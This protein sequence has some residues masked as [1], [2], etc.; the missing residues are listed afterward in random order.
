[1]NECIFKIV[2]DNASVPSGLAGEPPGPSPTLKSLESPRIVLHALCAR[3]SSSGSVR[4]SIHSFSTRALNVH[5]GHALFWN[6][7]TP[8]AGKQ[9]AVCSDVSDL[10]RPH[11]KASRHSVT[12]SQRSSLHWPFPA[13]PH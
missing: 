2:T 6:L 7:G 11:A 5:C 10:P 3:P 8:R 1:M 9:T 12:S 13:K 4:P